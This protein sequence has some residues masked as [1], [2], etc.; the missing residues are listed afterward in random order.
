MNLQAFYEGLDD[1]RRVP[2]DWKEANCCVFVADIIERCT[3]RVIELPTVTCE[4]DMLDWL[5]ANGHRS[6]FHAVR[7]H[8]GPSI[9]PLM[10]KRGDVL[11]RGDDGAIGV[12]DRQGWFVSDHGLVQIPLG[13]CTRAFRL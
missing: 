10:A 7:S 6:L 3:G 9:K 2:F 11:W 12:C 1:W 13:R 5:R 8:L 4:A